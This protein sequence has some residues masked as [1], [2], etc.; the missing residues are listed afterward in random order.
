MK[1]RYWILLSLLVS[2][3]TLIWLLLVTFTPET[4]AYIGEVSIA[5]LLLALGFRATTILCRVT[6]I[7]ILCRGL[8]YAVPFWRLTIIQLLSLFAG[9]VTPGQVGGEP[10]RIHRLTRSGLAVGDASAVV[11][12]ERMLDLGVLIILTL[13][14]LLA[15]RPLWGY[16]AAI[17]L[18]PVA[19]FLIL[20]LGLMFALFLLVRRPEI[21]KWVMGGIALR[22]LGWCGRNRRYLRFCPG[23]EGAEPLI[24]R[25]DNEVE[26]FSAG[27]SRFMGAGRWAGSGA[28]ALTILEWT[29]Y[30]STASVILIALGQPPSLPESF[31]FQGVLQMIAALPLIPGASGISEIGAATLYSRIMPT[32]LL[33][34]FVLLWRL[35]LYYLNIPL[36]LLAAVFVARERGDRESADP[37]HTENL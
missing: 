1:S 5:T 29:I 16:L 11:V 34:L 9:A 30:Y 37:R 4:R 24:E 25:L 18:Y 7:R 22:V 8:G 17:V 20:V 13:S 19:A 36:G 12:V 33:G 28:L 2:S 23:A 10:V 35:I 32:Y 26:I 31:L 6:R 3:A 14:A 21:M 15:L 27:L